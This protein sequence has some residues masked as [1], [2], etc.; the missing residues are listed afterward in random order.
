[1]L[2]EW[3]VIYGKWNSILLNVNFSRSLT[4]G[5]LICISTLSITQLYNKYHMKNIWEL[6]DYNME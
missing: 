3:S 5:I 4:K 6:Q 2:H 1:M